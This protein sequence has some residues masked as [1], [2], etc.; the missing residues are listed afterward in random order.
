MPPSDEITL[1]SETVTYCWLLTPV[2]PTTTALPEKVGTP[3]AAVPSVIVAVAALMGLSNV[4]TIVCDGP[5]RGSVVGLVTDTS[6]KGMSNVPAAPCTFRDAALC[7]IGRPV[8]FA[9][10]SPPG[11]TAS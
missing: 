3:G 9:R 11:Y 4:K 10:I 1:V 2:R 7:N 8:R 6:D 5:W